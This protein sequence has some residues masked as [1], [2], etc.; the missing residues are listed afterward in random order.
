MIDEIGFEDF[1][2]ALVALWRNALLLVLACFL[3]LF[4]GL[5]YTSFTT[6]SNYYGATA[7]VYS[8]T[9]GSYQ[10]T[11][12]E[13]KALTN[14]ADIIASK[15]V[16][17]DAAALI[18]DSVISSDVIK[19]SIS[20]KT[21]S[22]SYIMELTAV[23]SNPENAIMIVN[24]VS[25]AFVAEVSRVTGSDSIQ[26]LDEAEKAFIYRSNN[27]TKIRMLFVIASLLLV[28]AAIGLHSLFSNKLQ[29]VK[30][31]TDD[32]EEIIGIIPLSKL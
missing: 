17:E 32:P 20:I 27:T 14:Y 10:L 1:R 11:Q 25:E 7:S 15:K 23:S 21:D 6:G 18:K 29:S 13:V 9:Y 19:N 5:L 28:A 2:L 8:A 16:A 3:G 31:C 24:A 30:Q 12:T 22:S 4:A 26:I